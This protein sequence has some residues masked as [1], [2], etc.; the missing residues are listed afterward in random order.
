MLR[1]E[2][3]LAWA[4]A[5]AGCSYRKPGPR[6]KLTLV[7]S[8]Q[9]SMSGLYLTQELGFFRDAGLDVEIVPSTNALQ[10]MAALSGGKID[11]VFTGMQVSFLNLVLK[12]V[13]VR[14]MAGREIAAPACGTAGVIYG[15]R[16]TFPK[17]LADLRQLKGKRVVTGPSIGFS[18]FVLDVHLAKVGLSV[19][20]IS[21]LVLSSSQSLA[22]LIGGSV[23]AVVLNNDMDRD[24]SELGSDLVR[25]KRLADV[26]PEFQY[27]YI[28][29]GPTLLKGD[30]DIGARFL[31]AYL[32]G[33][34]EFAGGR[35]PKFM[36]EFAGA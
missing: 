21:P 30:V 31:A 18:Q 14:I 3:L 27:S 19:E 25:S 24:L 26:H 11:I 36:V 33:A 6:R 9:L 35:S 23:D 4:C 8:K 20:D 34:R 15:L 12:G 32:R 1:R 2:L 5:G 7:A 16:R 17:G 10:S 28:Y 13:P 22:A 29:C